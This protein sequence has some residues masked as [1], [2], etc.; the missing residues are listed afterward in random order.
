M[1]ETEVLVHVKVLIGRRYMFSKQGRVTLEKQWAQVT[2]AYPLQII[3]RDIT[4]HDEKYSTYRD[5][6]SIFP[7]GSNCFMLGHPYYG[8]MGEVCYCFIYNTL[9]LFLGLISLLGKR[10]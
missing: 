6:E 2:S 1:G 10:K 3:V 5:L 4:V 8:C 7:T 9:A